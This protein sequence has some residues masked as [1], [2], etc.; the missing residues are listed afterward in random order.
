MLERN[1]FFQAKNSIAIITL[2]HGRMKVSELLNVIAVFLNKCVCTDL[3][4]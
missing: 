2:S 1:N 4:V 3:H